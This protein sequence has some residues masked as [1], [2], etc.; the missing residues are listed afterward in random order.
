[1]KAENMNISRMLFAAA[2]L[3]A[4][5]GCG[6]V[7]SRSDFETLINGLSPVDVQA[8]VGKPAAVEE[9]ADTIRWT[10][11]KATFATS[12]KGSA[13]FDKKTIIVFRKPAGNVPG[14]VAEVT[15]E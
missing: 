1:M 2:A 4:I 11:N 5:A 14:T 13:Q 10:Y 8:K 15:Y 3:V 12:E 7:R 9:S 6:D